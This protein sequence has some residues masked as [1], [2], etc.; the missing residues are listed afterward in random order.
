MSGVI[1]MGVEEARARF[2]SGR[3]TRLK[4]AEGGTWVNG[5]SVT[6]DQNLKV[7]DLELINEPA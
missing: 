7:T 5:L 6:L 2:I 1:G 4:V 3:H